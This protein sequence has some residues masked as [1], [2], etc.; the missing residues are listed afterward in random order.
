MARLRSEASLFLC[1][2]RQSVLIFIL[3]LLTVSAKTAP[4]LLR[5]GLVELQHGQLQNA[6]SDLKSASDLDP[7]NA[8]IW[9]ALADGYLRAG[10]R[11]EAANAAAKAEQTGRG[12]A[13]VDHSL[14]LYYSKT[15]QFAKAAAA[16]ERY[17]ASSRSDAQAAGRAAAWYLASGDS[18]HALLLAKRDAEKDPETAFQLAQLFLRAQ[19]F[20]GASDLLQSALQAHKN[21]PQLLLAL[22]VARYGQRRFTDAIE[23][24]LKVIDVDPSIDQPYTFLAKMLDQASPELPRIETATRAWQQKKPADATAELVLAKVLLAKS[25]SSC[26]ECQSLLEGSVRDDP[27]N[28]EAHF[29]LG[30]LLANKRDY[31]KAASELKRAAELNEKQPMPHYHLAR[32][33]DRLGKRD[34]AAAERKIHEHLVG[35][36]EPVQP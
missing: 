28:W 25:P 31:E 20:A 34:E 13:I 21:D 18:A 7:K 3:C 29:Q 19:D 27:N 15:E 8:Y 14:A 4:D 5:Q 12:N 9:S 10:N 26:G 16:E 11:P 24:F 33:Y 23:L 22:G 35:A 17:A 1:H 2:T 30:L 32:M 6:I 36:P